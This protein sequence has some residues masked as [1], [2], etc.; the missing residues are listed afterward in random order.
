ML[1]ERNDNRRQVDAL[2]TK[3]TLNV[4]KPKKFLKEN[5]ESFNSPSTYT[6]VQKSTTKITGSEPAQNFGLV[7]TNKVAASYIKKILAY[8]LAKSVG[9]YRQDFLA[10]HNITQEVRTRMVSLVD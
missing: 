5:K 7:E 8:E 10:R 4:K 6:S 1:Q 2:S 9:A 3:S